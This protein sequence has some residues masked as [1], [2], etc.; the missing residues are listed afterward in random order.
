MSRVEEEVVADVEDE[1]DAVEGRA[2]KQ[3]GPVK[4]IYRSD[5][6]AKKQYRYFK[7]WETQLTEDEFKKR[8]KEYFLGRLFYKR[9]C[10]LVTRI[11]DFQG[12]DSVPAEK[13]E[14]TV[15]I[16]D[17]GTAKDR[18]KS[19]RS[20]GGRSFQA[21]RK[22]SRSRDKSEQFRASRNS[23]IDSTNNDVSSS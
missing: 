18:K 13:K 7:D 11:Q 10:N 9:L 19:L 23:A 17:E 14:R 15:T 12:S 3:G 8:K 22:L 6:A 1:D 4:I 21:Y 16:E 20:S 5:I 2:S